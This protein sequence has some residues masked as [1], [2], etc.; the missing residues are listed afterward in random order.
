MDEIDLKIKSRRR[1]NRKVY[2]NVV[3]EKVIWNGEE[4][5]SK[6]E[7]DRENRRVTVAEYFKIHHKLELRFPKMPLVVLKH[8]ELIRRGKKGIGELQQPVEE[9]TPERLPLEFFSQAWSKVRNVDHNPDVLRFN[10][11]FASTN[12]L[13][14][15]KEVKHLANR[16]CRPEL[17]MLLQQLHL[18]TDIE[19]TKLEARVLPQPVVRFQN[20]DTIPSDGS[21]NLTEVKFSKPAFMSSF[22]IIDFALPDHDNRRF[23]AFD[24]L[25][26]IMIRHGIEM[27]RNLDFRDSI[28]KVIVNQALHPGAEKETV[29]V[30]LD[31]IRHFSIFIL[32]SF[33]A[34]S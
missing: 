10:D 16:Q 32:N 20:V 26:N 7:Y 30:A 8:G 25:F 21:W 5:D 31:S 6:F 13:Q 29:S 15:L 24:N 27:P 33:A 14:H 18:T 17:S 12:R 1:F 22:A 19:P 28:R 34:D 2:R 23:A 9:R 11:Q 3:V 4:E